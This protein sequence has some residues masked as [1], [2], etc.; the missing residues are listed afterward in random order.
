[1]T[2]AQVGSQD[3][4]GRIDELRRRAQCQ[5]FTEEGGYVVEERQSDTARA[6]QYGERRKVIE[7][8][9]FRV[10]YSDYETN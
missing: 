5:G 10:F 7:I 2:D 6:E 4:A 3:V 8:D 9:S 1:M